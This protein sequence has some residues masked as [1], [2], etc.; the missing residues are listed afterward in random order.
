MSLLGMFQ[1]AGP[2]GFGYNSTA[3][4]VTDGRDLSG[5]TYL[6]TGCNSGLGAETMRVLILRGARVIAAARTEEKAAAAAKGLGGDVVPLAC[7]LSEPDSARAAAAR[8]VSEG[9][10]VDGIIANA[11]IMALPERTV[12]HGVEL[13][14][15]TNHVGHFLLVT[16]V[17]ERLTADAR[18]VMLSSAAHSSTWPEGV[19]LDDLGAERGYSS[20]RNY[21]QSKLANLLFAAELSRRL[22]AGQ[23]ANAV[24]PGVIPTNLARHMPGFV[25]A[26][27]GTLGPALFLKTVP[28]GAATQCYVATHPDVTT[29]GAYWAD[30]NVAK[31]SKHARDGALAE[32][33]WARTEEL[34]A[35]L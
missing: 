17:L 15:L 10:D 9:W 25:Q 30:C 8:I 28:Q 7:E 26:V 14:L 13:Q 23:T 5:R 3:E 24:H 19:R 18:V 32:A 27:F 33:L 1:G 12:R 2:S 21:G 16:G 6:L 4:D 29:G 35:T 22:P 34:V 11:G 31:S 20:F